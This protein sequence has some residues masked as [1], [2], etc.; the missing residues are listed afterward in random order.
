MRAV[1]VVPHLSPETTARGLVEC[2]PAVD[3]LVAVLL[4]LPH[5]NAT[6]VL[7]HRRGGDV[8]DID[9]NQLACH[10]SLGGTE[11]GVALGRLTNQ[12]RTWT[13]YC[14]GQRCLGLDINDELYLPVDED[15]FPDMEQQ[16][17]AWRDHPPAAW[18]RFRSCH[19]L[20]MKRTFSCRFGPI[21]HALDQLHAGH[22]VGA[23]T[24]AI[25]H[26]GEPLHPPRAL[27]WTG[28]GRPRS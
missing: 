17:I 25:V 20:G 27:P 28:A 12:D 8:A 6:A 7:F 21:Q 26:D 5:A 9:V 16:P 1:L 18:G 13:S 23:R 19:D 3:D 14:D 22:D 11:V 24:F 2:A 15:G 10:L 4:P